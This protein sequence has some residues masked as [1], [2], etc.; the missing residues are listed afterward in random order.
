MQQI[1]RATDGMNADRVDVEEVD[2]LRQVIWIYLF[3]GGAVRRSRRLHDFQ[4]TLLRCL[5][6]QQVRAVEAQRDIGVRRQF[7][8]NEEEQPA[9]N[10][11]ADFRRN[12]QRAASIRNGCSGHG[13]HA[14]EEV[15]ERNCRDVGKVCRENRRAIRVSDGQRCDVEWIKAIRQRLRC[16]AKRHGD[17]Q[18]L[19]RLR[20]RAG[21]FKGTE[22]KAARRSRG[23]GAG[24]ERDAR[25][26]RRAHG[27]NAG[28][29]PF[30]SQH[31]DAGLLAVGIERTHLRGAFGCVDNRVGAAGRGGHARNN[32]QAL[33]PLNLAALLRVI[34]RLGLL[35]SIASRLGGVVLSADGGYAKEKRGANCRRAETTGESRV[36]HNCEICS[37][38]RTAACHVFSGPRRL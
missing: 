34:T 14:R 9:W 15:S 13:L 26:R 29:E 7:P 17:G 28:S 37:K 6:R 19:A 38:F 8:R 12:H 5:R 16:G 3:G 20:S 31:Y 32:P 24:S 22:S 30:G 2:A 33:D 36:S 18:A 25:F 21:D 35:S 27:V 23:V 11:F 1:L 10:A 4:E